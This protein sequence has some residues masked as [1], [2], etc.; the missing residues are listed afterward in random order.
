M[1]NFKLGEEV[2]NEVINMSRARDKEKNLSSQQDLQLW[3]S[4]HRSDALTTEL[5]RIRGEL[6][7]IQSSCVRPSDR[8]TEGHRFNSCPALRFFLCLMLCSWHV[9]HITSH[10]FTELKVYLLSLFITYITISYFVLFGMII[11]NDHVHFPWSLCMTL[12]IGRTHVIHEP[13]NKPFSPQVLRSSVV[14]ASDRCTESHRFNTCRGLRCFLC[15]M[16]L[17]CWSHHFWRYKPD[18]TR[19]E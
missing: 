6:C 17:T 5:R 14:R 11:R 19:V 7:H 15:P 2:R 9:D 10:S 18:T 8:C 4:V 13:C 1:V 12:P 3:P 16:L